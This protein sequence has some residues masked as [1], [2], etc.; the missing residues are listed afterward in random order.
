[1]R[2]LPVLPLR[3]GPL[4]PVETELA[5]GRPTSVAALRAAFA[6]DHLVLA[7][8]QR[9]PYCDEP[10]LDGYFRVGC[11]AH[12][13]LIA[14]AEGI[15]T[16]HASGR[17]R[18][19][20]E[21]LQASDELLTA[22]ISPLVS[23]DAP[24]LD[25]TL[26]AKLREVATEMRIATDVSPSRLVDLITARLALDPAQAQWFLETLDVQ[27]RANRLLEPTQL[28]FEDAKAIEARAERESILTRLFRRRR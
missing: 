23:S 24:P 6:A 11:I 19:C 21:T 17:E 3:D 16:V 28:A 1:M 22:T 4:L 20:V 26:V 5:V 13:E 7:L 8:C 12:V 10:P 14:E 27:A 15:F 25:E 2:Q 9:D 18:A